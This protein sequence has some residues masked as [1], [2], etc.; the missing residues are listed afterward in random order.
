MNNTFDIKR[1]WKYLR[2]D[3]QTAVG[4]SGLTL[5]ILGAMPVFV[6][7]ITEAFSLIV[8][9]GTAQLPLAGKAS[10]CLIAAVVAGISFPARHYGT[11]TDKK[12]GSDWLMLPASRLEKWLSVLLMTCLAVPAFLLLELAATDGLLSLLFKGTYGT[13]ALGLMS[14]SM[15][16]LWGQMNSQG[17]G[18]LAISWPYATYLNWCENVLIFTLGAM[19]FKK[20]KVAKTFLA[21]FIFGMALS[22]LGAAVLKI[23]GFDGGFQADW[24]PEMF[25]MRTMNVLIYCI[26]ALFFILMDGA[27][28]L[29]IKNLK[30]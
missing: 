16:E 17:L 4:D 15:G 24:Q 6:Y 3:F 10:A 5:A 11:L 23:I 12:A 29:R 28:Y 22:M 1:F 8:S 19:Y 13:S 14:S 7:F 2:H 26:Y 25:S 18:R 9:G 30:H 21:Y 20:G 27:L